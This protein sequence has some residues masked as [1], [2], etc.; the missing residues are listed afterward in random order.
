[1]NYL[2]HQPR[3]DWLLYEGH[4]YVGDRT[5]HSLQTKFSSAADQMKRL[6]TKPSDNELLELYGLYKQATIG[7]VNIEKPGMLDM[8]GKAKWEAWN[9]RK[10]T[11]QSSAKEA[12]ITVA[13]K[14]VTVYGV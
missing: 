11:S 14:L 6:K 4:H 12:Y 10:G 8:K 9:S 5:G 1:M 7:D 13:D 2:G 3:P